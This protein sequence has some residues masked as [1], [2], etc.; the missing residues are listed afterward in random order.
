M[1]PIK[2]TLSQVRRK[3]LEMGASEQI[4]QDDPYIAGLFN[5]LQ[6]LR[7][8]MNEAKKEAAA[9]A[10]RPYLETID[11][12]EKRYGVYIRLRATK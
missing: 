12:V 2:G 4:E 9:E 1:T 7:Q 6:A 3:L 11:A 8:E 5:Q 10:A